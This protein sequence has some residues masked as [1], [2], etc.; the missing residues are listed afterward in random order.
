MGQQ[1]KKSALLKIDTTAFSAIFSG[2]KEDGGDGG[3]NNTPLSFT[4]LHSTPNPRSTLLFSFPPSLPRDLSSDFVGK[5]E[6]RNI[7]NFWA[8]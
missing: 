7:A 8:G 6:V 5:C 2:D 3:G 1:E 4:T